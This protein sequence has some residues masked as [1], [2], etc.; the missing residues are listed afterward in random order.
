MILVFNPIYLVLER[1]LA[2]IT[3][4]KD[5]FS[6]VAHGDNGFAA[7]QCAIALQI[8]LVPGVVRLRA[9]AIQLAVHF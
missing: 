3:V 6:T 2:D 8:L 9:V 1:R 5:F 7:T 4:P